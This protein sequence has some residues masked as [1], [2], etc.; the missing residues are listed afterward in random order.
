MWCKLF[1]DKYAGNHSYSNKI[2]K[3][4]TIKELNDGSYRIYKDKK[5]YNFVIDKFGKIYPKFL[6]SSDM[7]RIYCY[8]KTVNKIEIIY[9][10]I[11]INSVILEEKII[12]KTNIPNIDFLKRLCI[13]HSHYTESSRDKQN[14]YCS[15]ITID[16]KGGIDKIGNNK[17][18]IIDTVMKSVDYAFDEMIDSKNMFTVKL[19]KYQKCNIYWMLQKEKKISTI[20]YNINPIVLLDR[21]Y[22]DTKYHTVNHVDNRNSLSLYGG[23]LIDEV[24]LGKTLQII[25]LSLLNPRKS[26][27]YVNNSDKI[28]F[29]SSATLIIC[30]NHLCGQ[31]TRELKGKISG[32]NN[33][34]IITI[35]TKRH[36]NKYTYQ[37]LLDAHFVIVSYTFFGNK[38]F[39][40]PFT[41][42]L[43]KNKNYFGKE[44]NSLDVANVRDMFEKMGKKLLQ[45]PLNSLNRTNAL[46]PLIHWHRICVDE[47]HEVYHNKKYT[48]VKN[49]LQYIKAT[50]KW[51]IT[52]T[53][54]VNKYSLYNTIDYLSDYLNNDDESILISNDVVDYISTQCFRHNTKKSIDNEYKLPPI[55][56]EV[57]WLKFSATER[58]MY[59]AYLANNNNEKF[60]VYLRKL[61]CH[62]QLADETKHAL[63]GC[64]TL[65]EIERTML[66]HYK[67]DVDFATEKINKIDI[68]I[69]K[70]K[71]KIKEIE[72]RQKKKLL[73]KKGIDVSD[74]ITVDEIDRLIIS[75]NYNEE[76]KTIQD[77][78]PLITMENLEDSLAKATDSRIIAVQ[79]L[80]G[81]QA[82]YDF[83]N[84]V[85]TRLRNTVNKTTDMTKK[86]AFDKKLNSDTNIMDLISDDMM[87]DD[88]EMCGICMSEILEEDVGVTTC[89][90]IF[91]FSCLT[92]A[93]KIYKNCPMCRKHLR[94]IDICKLSFEKKK[95]EVNMTKA[96]KKRN[97]LINE[98]GTKLANLIFYLR[99]HDEHTIIFSQWDDLLMRVGGILKDNNIKNVFC[100]GNC[101][102]RDKAIRV[103][104]NTSNIKV[105]MLSSDSAASGTNLTKATQVILLDPIYGSYEY[106]KNQEKQAI[107]RA[108]RL[109]QQNIIKVIRFIIKNSIEEEIYTRN[110]K[111]DKEKALSFLKKEMKYIKY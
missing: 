74:E 10:V 99:E 22:Y 102:Q 7:Y 75:F 41:K 2:T 85:I 16:G 100:K 46:F 93:T 54:F 49:V 13:F 8:V 111:E 29:Y 92:M 53:P 30:P 28:R 55:K 21:V 101:Y 90:H 26:I 65:E 104:N 86:A 62:P 12:N 68:R 39:T 81:K 33:V 96:E 71:Q 61:C 57:I 88:E 35:L 11:S 37:D 83:Y 19:Y 40:D 59:N 95:P 42:K 44:W 27:L 108:H 9:T 17:K 103:F 51:V 66:I 89:G 84:N 18:Y 32:K 77:D 76:Y 78:D 25:A 31:W 97:E 109:G 106:R 4:T 82:T 64:K 43:V 1:Y 3:H 91:C 63:S 36:F 79:K 5:A 20:K 48:Y 6:T 70:I 34:D 45:N 58:M 107:G 24:G 67:N 94:V 105:I 98:I 56:E 15:D 52:A 50:Y 23:G 14:V 73:K 87:N 47:F 110:I 72:T 38:T 69:E 60:G 80:K